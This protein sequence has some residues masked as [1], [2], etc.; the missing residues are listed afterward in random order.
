MIKSFAHKAGWGF[1][2]CDETF[3]TYGKDV[4]LLRS[5]SGL[6]FSDTL[7]LSPGRRVAF[8]V[9][10]PESGKPVAYNVKF[11]TF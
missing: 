10:V 1:V 3:A 8:R 2:S 4:F 6:P 9:K 7:R 5:E 11:L